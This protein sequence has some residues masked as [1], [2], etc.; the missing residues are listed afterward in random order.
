MGR[1]SAAI[2]AGEWRFVAGVTVALLAIT[3]APYVYAW[4]SAP[5]DRQFMGI[6]VN[7]PDHAQYFAWMRGLAGAHLMSNT[8]TPEPNPP[9]FFNLLWWTVGRA[10]RALGLGYGGSLQLLRLVAAPLFLVAVYR[11]CALFL[12]DRLL[13]RVAFLVIAL[14]SGFGW[15]LVALKYTLAGG[16][17]YFPLDVHIAEGNT[18]YCLLAS[19]HFIAAAL[20][21][22]VF[23]LLLYGEATGR[24]R[25]DVAAGL[26]TLCLGWQHAYDLAAVYAILFSYALL[27]ALRDRRLPRQLI[28]SSAIIAALSFWPGLYSVLLTRLEPTWRVVLGQFG[29][30]GVFTPS[31]PHL[32]I[33]LGPVLLLAV[34]EAARTRHLRALDDRALFLRAW[35]LGNFAVIYLPVDWQIH[36]L[37]GWQVPLGILATQAVFAPRVSGWTAGARHRL[38]A[39]LLLAVVPTNLYLY[40]WRF[41]DLARHERPYYLLNDELAALAWLDAHVAPGDVV[42]SS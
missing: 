36:L 10:G 29:N 1:T 16:E 9:L 25:W 41:V 35:F 6:L 34:F 24:R 38:A 17:L 31:L 14:T 2:D 37:N 4:W 3:S 26:L 18:F 12:D 39:L 27:R 28:E 5:P 22:V 40:A 30:A 11:Q 20:Y 33:L 42:L 23:E 19:P 15:V 21:I 32:V 7:V 13:R 8:L